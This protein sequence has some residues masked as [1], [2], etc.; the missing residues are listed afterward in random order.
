MI[1]TNGFV[2]KTNKTPREEIKLAKDR[3]KDYIERISGK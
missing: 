3:R 1:L 2:K